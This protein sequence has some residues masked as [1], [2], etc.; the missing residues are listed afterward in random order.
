M[1][2]VFTRRVNVAG[3][4][5]VVPRDGLGGRADHFRRRD[6]ALDNPGTARGQHRAIADTEQRDARFRADAA[7]VDLQAGGDA[8]QRKVAAA[9][10]ELEKGRRR[11]NTRRR[12]SRIWSGKR[13]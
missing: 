7:T 5:D 10:R 3:R 2:S 8:R 13:E 11:T 6:L 12:R 1:P 9:T 4:I